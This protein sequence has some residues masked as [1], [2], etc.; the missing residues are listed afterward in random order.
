MVLVT[1]EFGTNFQGGWEIPPDPAV[2]EAL[3]GDPPAAGAGV[4]I[5]E[6]EDVRSKDALVCRGVIEGA[7]VEVGRGVGLVTDSRGTAGEGLAGDFLGLAARGVVGA[8][9]GVTGVLADC[10]SGDFVGDLVLGGPGFLIGSDVAA[11]AAGEGDATGRFGLAG[12]TAD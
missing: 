3:V 11:I 1:G 9:L 8:D 4:L 12:G 6:G 7:L 2:G 5:A 10:L